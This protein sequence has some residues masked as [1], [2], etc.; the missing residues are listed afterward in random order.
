MHFNDLKI[1]SIPFD[2]NTDPNHGYVSEYSRFYFTAAPK[3]TLTSAESGYNVIQPQ[4][5]QVLPF[6]LHILKAWADSGQLGYIFFPNQGNYRLQVNVY[7]NTIYGGL[8]TGEIRD[9]TFG[10]QIVPVMVQYN[11]GW[12]YDV[13][14]KNIETQNGNIFPRYSVNVIQSLVCYPDLIQTIDGIKNTSLTP[15]LM[16]CTQTELIQQILPQTDPVTY[17]PVMRITTGNISPFAYAYGATVIDYIVKNNQIEMEDLGGASMTFNDLPIG[18][19]IDLYNMIPNINLEAFRDYLTSADIITAIKNY[20]NGNPINAIVSYRQFYIYFMSNN[21]PVEKEIT[22][23]GESTGITA[24]IYPNQYVKATTVSGIETLHADIP[25]TY[26][27]FLDYDPY[28]TVQLYLPY[29][30]VVAIDTSKCMGGSIDIQLSVDLI[31]GNGIYQ[32]LTTDKNR[33][34]AITYSAQGQVGVPVPYYA[35]DYNQLI[36]QATG[37]VF[38]GLA[39]VTQSKTGMISSDTLNDFTSSIGN[40][41]T[42]PDIFAGNNNPVTNV[43]GLISIC[44]YPDPYII[45]TRQNIYNNDRLSEFVG[46]KSNRLGTINDGGYGKASAV[47]WDSWTNNTILS[48]EI[49][50]ID[51]LLKSG[52]FI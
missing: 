34:S 10:T 6:P 24:D 41:V 40:L 45:I 31:S 17:T 35:E 25:E 46:L 51:T 8:I 33:V 9:P 20:F 28:T 22:L 14:P 5:L 44:G 12:D 39:V 2:Y 15:Q 50:Q 48:S 49:H 29:C 3:S 26:N 7:K 18:S 43:S 32:I 30:G 4:I 16:Q 52:V 27:S 42:T 37:V 19:P 47:L 36:S 38:N 13:L 11:K 23:A 1:Y 21:T